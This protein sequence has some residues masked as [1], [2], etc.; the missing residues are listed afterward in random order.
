LYRSRQNHRGAECNE[1]QATQKAVTAHI[2][3]LLGAKFAP[4]FEIRKSEATAS[5][6]QSLI[7]LQR[8]N[9]MRTSD[10]GRPNQLQA[11]LTHPRENTLPYFGALMDISDNWSV[12]CK[13]Y[14]IN[15]QTLARLRNQPASGNKPA[16]VLA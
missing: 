2:P 13:T 9:Q 3:F 1:A 15:G 6:G 8:F 10:E 5:G 12:P 11:S 16:R 4:C 14:H 7:C